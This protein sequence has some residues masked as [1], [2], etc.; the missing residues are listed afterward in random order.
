[1]ITGPG[2]KNQLPNPDIFSIMSEYW[3]PAPTTRQPTAPMSRARKLGT[4]AED[5]ITVLL[6]VQ[7]IG[8]LRIEYRQDSRVGRIFKVHLLVTENAA[9]FGRPMPA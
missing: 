5:G 7:C 6:Q 2:V 4:H 3:K 1:M 9:S 8:L